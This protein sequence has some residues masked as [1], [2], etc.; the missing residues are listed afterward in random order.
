MQKLSRSLIAVSAL[1]LLAACGDDVSITPPP[2]APPA[3]IARVDVIPAQLS[4]DVGEKVVLT[5]TV[6]V[7]Q[8]S[9]APATT[10]TWTS[11]NA[12]IASVSASGEVTGVAPGTTT[13]RATS[14]ADPSK[15]GAAAITVRQAAPATISI[16]SITTGNTFTP[17]NFNNV[18]GQIDVTL[19]V[20]PGDQIIT[21]VEVLVDG[22]VACTQGFSGL[23]SAEEIAEAQ[24]EVVCS[25]ATHEFDPVTGEVTFFNGPH[26]VTAR[27][28]LVGGTSVAT[29]STTLTFNNQ[30][31]FIAL[32]SNA[33]TVGGPE[34]A[35]NP[36]NGLKWIQGDV[37]LKLAA[38]NYAAGGATV[39]SISGAF[40]GHTFSGVTPDAGTQ[41][42]TLL[43]EDDP[44]G[45]LE[46][47]DYQTPLGSSQSI[48]VI[49][50]SSLSSGSQGPTQVVNIGAK[51]DT[52]GLTRFDSTRV[53]NVVPAAPTVGT[54]AVWLN[55]SFD[56]DTLSTA[57]TGI[58][59]TGVNDVTVEFW[60]I[61]GTNPTAACDV[62]GMTLVTDAS[63]L[64]EGIIST[65]YQGKVVVK[66]ALGNKTCS[67]LGN[68]FGVDFTPPSNVTLTGVTDSA[69]FN[70]I[71][72]ADAV[73]YILASTGD[74]ASG[75][76][77]TLPGL[78]SIL[79]TPAT[80]A[81]VC[82]L[83]S[84]STCVQVA[85]PGTGSITDNA[86]A[87]GYYTLTAQ[88]TDVAGNAAP[89]PAFT[90]LFLVDATAPTFTGNVGMNAQYAGNA[91][92]AFTNLQITD[93]L[94]LKR[95][96]G[97]VNYAAAGVDL[98]YPAQSIG[99][100]GLPL[101]K[102]FSGT[103]TIPS[104]IRCINP[105]NTFA[106]NLAAE[107]TQITFIAEDQ[108]NNQGTVAPV[109]GALQAAL[110]NCGAVGNVTA[111]AAINSF[112]DS[113]VN[114]G[115]GKTQVSIGGTTTTIN[116]ANVVL[117]TIVDVTLDNS[118]EPFTRVEYYYQNAA[119]NWVRIGQSAAGVLNQT[120]TTRTW[121]YKF[122]WDPDATVPVNAT[123]NVIAIGV[124]AQGDAVRTAGVVVNVAP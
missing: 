4:I 32:V 28:Q 30:S 7:N 98:E 5:A 65:E 84:G 47:D 9:G 92:A 27:A 8:G 57:I 123:T 15:V 121:T 120:V 83:G 97:V 90:R 115:T 67:P 87:E 93:N 119:G 71:A 102:T 50:S 46:I 36:I 10:V 45:D 116:S 82:E 69:S 48:P 91:P 110:D 16:K 105:A 11:A 76:S 59:D 58:S 43:F 118:P 124:D 23:Q 70:V 17:V 14:T 101:E 85:A 112:A 99:S 21:V 61:K 62:T 108:A 86:G 34:S 41:I 35:I 103:Y 79:R 52:L 80:G 39:T 88:M 106:L 56:F 81:N 12:A 19:N 63:G 72:T 109:V 1:V 64:T 77:A 114:Y 20:E 38:V 122:T 40:L 31:G 104:L 73:Q 37:T 2:E 54:F 68:T 75:I 117:T 95:L 111:P 113:A 24:A 29:P 94:D 107:A 44:A 60:V 22:V 6:Q 25:I 18:T 96:F 13:I 55:A 49:I 51:A 89:T 3:T 78:V 33:N 100:F 66:D 74:N 42:F 53:D 26:Q